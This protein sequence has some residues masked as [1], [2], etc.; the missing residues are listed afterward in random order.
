M[1]K[2]N[3]G[4][5]LKSLLSVDRMFQGSV[6]PSLQKAAIV[7]NCFCLFVC[8]FVC[9]FLSFFYNLPDSY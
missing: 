8:L 7:A 1:N 4:W 3:V 5:E 6:V 2:G 9:F